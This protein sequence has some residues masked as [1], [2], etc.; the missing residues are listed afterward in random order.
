VNRITEDGYIIG[1]N[2][3]NT[4]ILILVIV[5]AINMVANIV[6][7]VLFIFRMKDVISGGVKKDN[8]MTLI[9]LILIIF[10]LIGYVYVAI[11]TQ[12]NL[13][14]G[15]ILFFGSFFVSTAIILMKRLIKTSKE[16]SLE[17]AQVLMSVIDARGQNLYG[18]SLHV[19]NLMTVFYKHLPRYLKGDY[20]LISLEYAALLH[21]IGKLDMPKEILD[22]EDQ[23]NEEE[24]AV[25]RTHPQVAVR[26]LR[27][28]KS[29]SYISDWILFHHERI[30]GQGY[31]FKKA[32]SIPFP[33]KLIAI[34][35]TY[36]SIT[37]GRTYSCARTHEEALELIKQGAGSKF[38]EELVEIFV[39][40][41]KEEITAC[42]PKLK[43]NESVV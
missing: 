20:N 15:L 30:D 36:S 35:D 26:L 40:I 31:Y 24:K 19:K 4:L 14:T 6:F 1:E 32:D 17:I 27:P 13:V 43:N 5:G 12:M 25:L 29:F 41:P 23:I 3:M 22:D 39:S 33:S 38:D 2:F 37:M 16:R 9:G 8:I 21:D 18:H 10:F 42:L 28:I 34:V 7:Y 11:F